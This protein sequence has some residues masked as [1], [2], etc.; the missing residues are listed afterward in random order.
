[1]KIFALLFAGAILAGCKSQQGGAKF[2]ALGDSYTIGERVDYSQCWPVQL[3][4]TLRKHDTA[5]SDPTIIA[6]TGWTT[7]DLLVAM[8]HADLKGPYDVVGLLIGVNN[9]YQN[10]S[11]DEYREQFQLL[12]T[13]AITLAGNRPG[14]VFVLSIPDWG[15]TPYARSIGA[16]DADVGASIDRFN[17]INKEL[18]LK[19]GAVYVDITP[20]TRKFTDLIA[21]DGLHPSG[22]MYAKWVEAAMPAV[23]KILSTEASR[24]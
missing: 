20:I 12:L 8:D 3:V 6:Q 7:G 16:S 24:H 4:T 17:A 23:E 18:T 1:M 11:E 15:T 22:D 10:R 21:D 2:L 14:H 13:A 5:I 9:Q 19:A